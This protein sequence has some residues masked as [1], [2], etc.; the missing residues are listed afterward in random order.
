M[1]RHILP[2]PRLDISWSNSIGRARVSLVDCSLGGGV[3]AYRLGDICSWTLPEGH[4]Q[5]CI[6]TFGVLFM[7]FTE[8]GS[9]GVMGNGM[10]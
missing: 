3:F 4:M 2:Y 7:G 9:S 5:I 6:Q 8:R 1:G 10:K